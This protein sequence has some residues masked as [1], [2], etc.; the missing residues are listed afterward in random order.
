MKSLPGHSNCCSP[1]AELSIR[2]TRTNIPP[3]N[4]NYLNFKYSKFKIRGMQRWLTVILYAWLFMNNDPIYAQRT[5]GT[6][7]A[8]R[9]LNRSL[10]NIVG[11]NLDFKSGSG[12]MST[13]EA[14]ALITAINSGG[15]RGSTQTNIDSMTALRALS[16]DLHP[17][18]APRQSLT[19]T[20]LNRQVP[21]AIDRQLPVPVPTPLP[22]PVAALVAALAAF[23]AAVASGATPISAV[24]AAFAAAVA[25]FLVAILAVFAAIIPVP[26]KSSPIVKKLVIKKTVLPFVIPIPYK[27]KEKEK[28]KEKEVIYKYVKP[29]HHHHHEEHHH[30]HEHKK[31]KKHKKKHMESA[32]S[33]RHVLTSMAHLNKLETLVS[34]QD[35]LQSMV[36]NLIDD[37]RTG[38]YPAREDPMMRRRA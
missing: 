18:S 23:L 31:H 1:V 25:A 20:L 11:T 4:Q 29:H 21:T 15:N 6:M 8:S 7:M 2:C 28:E 22:A 5:L 12:S 32:A 34:E 17:P 33:E 35:K 14:I 26:K 36:N 38:G 9:V 27:K 19:S 30:E 24:F 37:K 13:A 16:G 3:L 10:R